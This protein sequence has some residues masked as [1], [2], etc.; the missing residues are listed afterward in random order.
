METFVNPVL[1][2]EADDAKIW[3]EVYIDNE[4]ELTAEQVEGKVVLDI[5]SHIGSFTM[6]AL[7]LGAKHVHCVEPVAAT[8]AIWRQNCKE[9]LLAG[10]CSLLEAVCWADGNQLIGMHPC[11]DSNARSGDSVVFNCVDTTTRLV[12]TVAFSDLLR[13]Y[14]PSVVKL[15]CEGAEYTALETVYA[16]PPRV[17]MF[18]IEYHSI[19]YI[20]FRFDRCNS[21]F[22]DLGFR[23]ERLKLDS[24]TQFCLM[25]YVR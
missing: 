24:T 16:L 11:R 12:R 3:Q 25:R 8:T 22:R 4:Y 20:R 23:A 13:V 7:S 19:N 6:K 15:D 21:L 17:K 1:R 18:L 5:G 9:P 10:K 14:E 2:P